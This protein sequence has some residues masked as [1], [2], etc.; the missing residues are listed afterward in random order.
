MKPLYRKLNYLVAQ[1][2]P[3]YSNFGRLRTPYMKLTVGD[4][5]YRIPGILNSISTQWNKNKK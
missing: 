2:S 5:F 3:N 4:Y 1:T